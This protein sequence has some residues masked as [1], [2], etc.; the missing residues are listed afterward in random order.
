MDR[1]EQAAQTGGQ[2]MTGEYHTH[3]GQSKD[4]TSAF[5]SL[6]N[7]L[8]AAFRNKDVLQDEANSAARFDNIRNG[9]AF[10]FLGLADHLRQSYNGVDG[11]GNGSIQYR[12]LCGGSD[13]A[14]GAGEA[15]GEG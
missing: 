2:W 8:A 12:L 1:E 10:D 11:Q 13:P 6:N 7:V 15:A 5:M 4:A 3:T 14:A 9:D